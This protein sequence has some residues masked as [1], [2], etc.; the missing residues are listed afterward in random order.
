MH[1]FR[2]LLQ[3]MILNDRQECINLFIKCILIPLLSTDIYCMHMVGFAYNLRRVWQRIH[4]QGYKSSSL[5][6]ID[7]SWHLDCEI[8]T[9]A[10][11]INIS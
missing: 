8:H 3:I 9:Q 6:W 10:R 2:N 11:W 5:E 1:G 4:A 7:I